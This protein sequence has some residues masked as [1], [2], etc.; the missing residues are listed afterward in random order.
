MTGLLSNDDELADK[1]YQCGLDSL[2]PAWRL[3]LWDEYQKLIDS[4]FADIANIG[5]LK[6]WNHYSGL[7]PG[8]VY[9][10]LQVGSS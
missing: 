7:F 3:P 9:Q 1:L 6:G 5:G 4:N 8:Q 10:R 2:D